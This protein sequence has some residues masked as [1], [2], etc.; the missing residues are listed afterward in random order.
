MAKFLWLVEHNGKHIAINVKDIVSV[1]DIK[2]ITAISAEWWHDL[3]DIPDEGCVVIW[4]QGEDEYV[5]IVS[6]PAEDICRKLCQL[7]DS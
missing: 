6:C 1:R 2:G 3:E 5:S 7:T 4:M